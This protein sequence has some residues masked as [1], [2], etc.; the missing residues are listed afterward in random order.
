MNKNEQYAT[1]LPEEY[2]RRQLN[3]LYREIPLK[4]TV[5]RL[6][7]KYFNAAA[8]LY[9][10]IPLKK[11]YEIIASQN[12][13]LV[14]EAE[15]LAF[16]E[17]AK[18]ENE[19]Y[20]ILGQSD[21]YYDGPETPLMEYEVID[22]ILIDEDLDKYHEIL[23]AHQEKPYYIPEK[24]EL[25]C[26]SDSFY[27]EITR[28]S[29]VL[30]QILSSGTGLDDT[31]LNNLFAAICCMTRCT[32]GGVQ[33]IIEW[34]DKMGVEFRRDR[35]VEAFVQA[36]IQFHNHARMQHNRGY[37][38]DELLAMRPPKGRMPQSVSFGY[39]IRQAVASGAIDAEDFKKSIL[40]MDLPDEALRASLL[41]EIEVA[42]RFS[43]RPKA[44]KIG[45]NDPCPCGSG[46]KYKK[47]CGR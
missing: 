22:A 47:C 21:L 24:K 3:A 27:W 8:N 20:F 26:Y 5:S 39:N 18:H 33:H 44:E 38:P 15:F 37:T 10:I 43:P 31:E 23:H 41:K 40:T 19:D 16:A 46:K 1:P 30:R 2:S 42:A 14:T 36:Y 17:I 34:L 35:D 12:K 25:L 13:A 45:R 29:L 7:R 9:G 11:L 4:D 6:L 32:S 28:E